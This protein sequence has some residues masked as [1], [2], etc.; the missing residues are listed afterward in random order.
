[1]EA[2]RADVGADMYNLGC[3]EA[4]RSYLENLDVNV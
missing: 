2:N 4:L 1:M 3:T